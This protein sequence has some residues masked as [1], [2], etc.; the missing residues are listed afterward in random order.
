MILLIGLVIKV[1]NKI[2][3]IVV[4]LRVTLMFRATTIVRVLFFAIF[5]VFTLFVRA[6]LSI[7]VVTAYQQAA[8]VIYINVNNFLSFNQLINIGFKWLYVVGE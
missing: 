5:M 4:V 6:E 7:H 2:L 3:I 8:V 1:I